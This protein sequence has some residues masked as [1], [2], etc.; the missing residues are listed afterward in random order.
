VELE[1]ISSFYNVKEQELF[2]EVFQLLK[3]VGA[4]EDESDGQDESQPVT[5]STD[6]T[7]NGR[8]R[9]ESFH[10][11]EDGADDSDD[12][13]DETTSL[14][15]KRRLSFPG[16]RRTVALV[17]AP[18]DMTASTEM[19]RSVRRHSVTYDDY[20]EQAVL[21]SSEIMLKKRIIGLY[22]SLCELKSYVQLNRTGFSKVLK[23]FDKILDRQ[24]KPRYLSSQVEPAYP[25][26]KETIDGL[27]DNIAKME[28]AYTEIVTNGDEELSKRDL[29][30][31]LREHVVWE[32]N[33]VWRDMISMER[34]TEAASLGQALLG[35]DADQVKARLQGDVEQLPPTFDIPTPFGRL[36]VPIWVLK[37][38]VFMIAIVGIFLALLFIPI[39]ESVEQQNCLALLIFVSLL[40]ATEVWAH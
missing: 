12:D 32:R 38:T 26:R 2:A 40:W 34:R 1:K 31:H 27:D 9:N 36:S 20:A 30:S 25:F 15:R 24:L 23:K 7:R 22:V 5:Q 8:A 10:S 29:R 6:R 4:H 13:G 14:T 37:P 21:F 39:M 33:T 3:D 18:T 28:Q 16:R 35:R 19:T 11:T 17:T